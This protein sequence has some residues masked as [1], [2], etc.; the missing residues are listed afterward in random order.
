[1]APGTARSTWRRYR[2]TSSSTT[3]GS[4]PVACHG[5]AGSDLHPGEAREAE[6]VAL[7]RMN[8]NQEQGLADAAPQDGAG[9]PWVSVEVLAADLADRA[10]PN[11]GA[12]SRGHVSG[13]DL[14][15]HAGARVSVQPELCLIH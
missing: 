10:T 1:M 6:P 7:P 12:A 13:E 11:A 2:P 8:S 14:A 3:P 5:P 4:I 9:A 15:K